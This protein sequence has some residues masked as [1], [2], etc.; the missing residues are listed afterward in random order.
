MPLGDLHGLVKDMANSLSNFHDKLH[1]HF[2][3]EI[4]KLRQLNIPENEALELV[5]E[6]FALIFDR[7]FDCR[8]DFWSALVT[9][10]FS[11]W[12]AP[13][14]LCFGIICIWKHS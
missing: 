10:P 12:S 4:T 6:Q 2:E 9:I 14:G 11:T 3:D 5:S 8:Q 7:L 1:A 13:C